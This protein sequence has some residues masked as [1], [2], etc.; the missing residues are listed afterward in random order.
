L[1]CDYSNIPVSAWFSLWKFVKVYEEFI[2]CLKLVRS[3]AGFLSKGTAA[4]P[5]SLRAAAITR[6]IVDLNISEGIRVPWAAF[7]T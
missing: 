3:S 5:G 2:D 7:V 6:K 1:V 4:P